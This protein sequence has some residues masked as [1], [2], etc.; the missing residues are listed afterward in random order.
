M[1]AA[2]QDYQRRETNRARQYRQ[3]Q[4]IHDANDDRAD[5]AEYRADCRKIF[6]RLPETLF[7]PNALL[8][9]EYPR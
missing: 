5:Y 7:S 4:M 9:D 6:H 1:N 3:A 8:D 2:R